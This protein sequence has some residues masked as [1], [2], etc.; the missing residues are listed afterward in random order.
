MTL[1]TTPTFQ[2]VA[3]VFRKMPFNLAFTVLFI[4]I[5]VAI[6]LG[7][8]YF[9]N[10]RYIFRAE[11][12]SSN[13]DFR[14]IC[15]L[16][17]LASFTGRAFFGVF[18]SVILF[19]ALS[20]VITFEY[21]GSYILPF[22]IMQIFPDFLLIMASLAEVIHEI[23]PI[24]LMGVVA[25]VLLVIMAR[26]ITRRR[27]VLPWMW[28]VIL[29]VLAA[30][31]VQ[32]RALL[33]ENEEKMAEASSRE[34]WPRANRL[35]AENAY[36]SFK[37]LTVGILPDLI[38]NQQ[39]QTPAL[40]EPELIGPVDA[41]V[42][43]I[44]GETVRSRSMSLLGYDLDTTPKLRQIDG[45]FATSVFPAGTMTRTTFAGLFH[46][47]KYPGL[48]SQFISQSNCLFRLA[49]QN[50]FQT[51][52]LYSE[53]QRAADTLMPFMCPDYLDR[54]RVAEDAPD[55]QDIFDQNL[56]YEL[57]QIDLDRPN[58]IT[59]MPRGAHS[60]YNENTPDAFKPFDHN[61][62]NSILYFDHV[63]G[64]IIEKLRAGS[65][66][67]TY[68]IVTGDHGELLKGESDKRGHGWFRRDVI[69][70]P[71]LFLTL[72]NESTEYSAEVQKVRSHFD[73]ATLI[74]RLIGYDS[75]VEDLSKREI[76]VNG[77][78]V[79]GLAGQLKLTIESDQ[80]TAVEQINGGGTTPMLDDLK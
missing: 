39:P 12:F 51:H 67:T 61:Y 29:L 23:V 56:Y 52:F 7:Y 48:G 36:R 66:R 22:Q 26:P 6:D 20:Q 69:R 43:L 64:N 10:E 15:A 74:Q 16:F 77:S 5:L 57:D 27:A 44:L 42:V 45:L 63:V 62:D 50:G 13:K 49:K 76:Y 11:K 46:R 79:S 34:L 9:V 58:F 65:D 30:D 68:V 55:G 32:T 60:P 1:T 38:S 40:D 72:N 17:L 2:K 54:V 31:F 53:N 75:S 59:I 8:H 24:L 78:D 41:N 71:F 21:F 28:C 47:L 19:V 25:V 4:L 3:G 70:V 80:L 14:Q 37:L 35:G 18:F 33:A 73:I